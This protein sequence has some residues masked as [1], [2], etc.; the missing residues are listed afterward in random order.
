MRREYEM[1]QEQYDE[2]LDACR[3]V[4]Y[5]VFGGRPPSSPQENAN[6]AWK[7]LGREMGFQYMSVKSVPN[8]PRFFT[9][10][11]EVKP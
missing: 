11:E 2:L 10:E 8:Q 5:M 1:T 7:R 3:P 6:N 4:P 9:A